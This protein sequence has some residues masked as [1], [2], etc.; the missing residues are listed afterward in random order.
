MS[1]D[2]EL[3]AMIGDEPRQVDHEVD[4]ATDRATDYR[5]DVDGLRALAVAAVVVFHI[6]PDLLP[7]GF[8]GV[9]VFFVISGFVVAA[10]LLDATS[11][12][13]AAYLG[14]FYC[15]RLKRLTPS[16]V[17]VV[18]TVGLLTAMF[19]PVAT[20]S[21]RESFATGMCALFGGANVY[22]AV[23]SGRPPPAT[24]T[25]TESG[26]FFTHTLTTVDGDTRHDF[27]NDP[28]LHTWSLGVEEQ[29]YLVLP[30]VVW[31][32][33]PRLPWVLGVLS[34]LSLVHSWLLTES[35]AQLA[36]YLVTSR[37]WELCSGAILLV[38][39]RGWDGQP[40]RA[41]AAVLAVTSG[42][43]L[44]VAL[45]W[46]PSTHGFPAP[47]ALLAVVGTMCFIGAGSLDRGCPINWLLA[48]PPA[49]YLGRIS[50]PL[51]L[52]HWPLFV[53]ARAHL[54]WGAVERASA[55]AAALVGA[56]LCYRME[57]AI[58]GWRPRKRVQ[59]GCALAGLGAC[60]LWLY[61]LSGSGGPLDLLGGSTSGSSDASVCAARDTY[62]DLWRVDDDARDGMA[63]MA[64]RDCRCRVCTNATHTP[65]GAASDA[66][67]ACFVDV[68]RP[69]A[70]QDPWASFGSYYAK[71]RCA[72]VSRQLTC[73][74]RP[75][76]I[77]A[78]LTPEGTRPR[79]F[80]GGDSHMD[81][82]VG[83]LR[84]AL[85]DRYEV[86]YATCGDGCAFTT[87]CYKYAQPHCAMYV[88]TFWRQL[89]STLAPGDAV[90][91]AQ[92]D[93][94]VLPATR[95]GTLA[96]L[97]RLQ[98]LVVS[99]NASLLIL[100]EVPVLRMGGWDCRDD[101]A[102]CDTPEA[103]AVN[104]LSSELDRVYA[105]VASRSESTH[106]YSARGLF[107][108]EGVCGAL[109]PGTRTFAYAD[110]HHITSEAG[111]YLAP[112]LSC[113]FQSVGLL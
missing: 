35:D 81:M 4:R 64:S 44:A 103:A 33:G 16:L 27:H 79:F 15:R 49:V 98:A 24:T 18:A 36:F 86:L 20:A 32:T 101:L 34:A 111:L 82:R 56:A 58:R 105:E 85:Q 77:V 84:A 52:W 65:A 88:D 108:A 6:D 40:R 100:G 28:F 46:T 67:A 43:L 47:Y 1:A 25:T 60:C 89:E 94:W 71:S 30:L 74:D 59:V 66:A 90:G 3:S 13:A 29:F 106:F 68:D 110:T 63:P 19:P 78:C 96:F 37:F 17:V 22:L 99:R 87:G 107:C 75:D 62:T 73:F 109:I 102:L 51:Y 93:G 48:R 11:E 97:D 7:G 72:P 42:A 10:S 53:L 5:P 104:P 8:V 14:G 21:L 61:L 55:C 57:S 41:A 54:G 12:T 95:A 91:Y 80:L 69:V 76:E 31:T 50:Y 70:Q 23:L 113:Y 39:V 112:F 45:A 2:V 9:D 83:A 26:Y 92:Y 38:A